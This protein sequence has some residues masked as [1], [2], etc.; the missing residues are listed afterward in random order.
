M[1]DTPKNIADKQLEIWMKKSP[2]ERLETFL[3]DNE[4][5][6]LFWKQH[7]GKNKD[8][9]KSKILENKPNNKPQNYKSKPC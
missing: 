8:A 4:A 1:T 5:L 7:H 9:I 2:S 6:Y 3:K